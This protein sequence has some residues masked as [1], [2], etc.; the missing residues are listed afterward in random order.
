M[1]ID[2]LA[3]EVE[4]LFQ[5]AR[6]VARR[7][8]HTRVDAAHVL[9]AALEPPPDELRAALAAARVGI[10]ELRDRLE[11]RLA[12]QPRDLARDAVPDD[13]VELADAIRPL[14]RAAGERAAGR[15]PGP[16]RT[17]DVIDALLAAPALAEAVQETGAD[18]AALRRALDARSRPEAAPSGKLAE[19]TVDLTAQARAGQLDPVIGREPEIR[20]LV[21]VLSR[22]RKNNP[23]LVG[24]AGVGKTAIVEGL[25]QRIV[26]GDVP[27]GLKNK[28][29]VALDLGSLIAGTRFR[30]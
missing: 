10:V 19:Y 3:E 30:G 26:A 27:E 21:H 5:G 4:A 25:A 11:R 17:V 8:G 20:Q 18:V 24:E 16:V 14:L 29:V 12:E 15:G 23:L 1:S 28:R 6:R 13:T 2:T 22:R 9:L 7:S